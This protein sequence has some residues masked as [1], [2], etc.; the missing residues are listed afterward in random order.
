MLLS[1]G[2]LL[3]RT[4]DHEGTI[5]TR[6]ADG[7]V[8]KRAAE[9]GSGVGWATSPVDGIERIIGCRTLAGG[10]VIVFA[11]RSAPAVYDS[12]R[13]HTAVVGGASVL[14][15]ALT[16]G[17]MLLRFKQRRRDRLEQAGAAQAQRLETMGRIAGGVAHDL[18]NTVK[19]ARTTF[20]LFGR[21]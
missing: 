11:G 21:R 2:T 5:G 14:V 17:L 12:W 15:W 19:I 1:D 10:S 18:G 6:F 7:A 13:E 9:Q 4:P 8:R 3:A 20:S 16:S